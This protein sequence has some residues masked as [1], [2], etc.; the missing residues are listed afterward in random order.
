MRISEPAEKVRDVIH[1]RVYAAP[2]EVQ[3]KA[4]GASPVRTAYWR[5]EPG[6]FVTLGS[7]GFV[8]ELARFDARFRTPLP[9]ILAHPQQ[10]GF[11]IEGRQIALETGTFNGSAFISLGTHASCIIHRWRVN[12]QSPH[13]DRLSYDIDVAAVFGAGLEVHDVVDD[14]EFMLTRHLAAYVTR[15]P[16]ADR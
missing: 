11:Q 16:Y 12:L 13:S 9:G 7:S 2:Q 5:A 14:F 1:R 3:L 10:A 8:S 15:V 6:F 4:F